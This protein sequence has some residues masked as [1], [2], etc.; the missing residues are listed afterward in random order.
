VVADHV[1]LL[2]QGV[3]ERGYDLVRDDPPQDPPPPGEVR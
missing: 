2:L 1:D 3:R